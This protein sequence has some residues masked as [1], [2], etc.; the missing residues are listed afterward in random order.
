MEFM[1]F[2]A[3]YDTAFQFRSKRKVAD[4]IEGCLRQY[5]AR[6]VRTIL[7]VACGTGHYT[8]E[9]ARRKYVTYGLDINRDICRYAR[10][11]AKAEALNMTILRGDMVHFALPVPCDLAVSFFDSLTYMPDV[12]ALTTHFRTVAQALAPQGLYIVEIGVIDDFENHNVEEVWT[13][14][15]RDFTV[16]TTYLRDGWINPADGTFEEHC[17]FR[18]SC[19]EHVAFFQLKF[20]KLALAFENFD[21]I[22]KRSAVFRPLAYYDSFKANALL[23]ANNAPWRVIAVLQK[24]A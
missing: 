10:R 7:D 15:R 9:F 5:A 23:N 2:P 11:R 24:T 22:V 1:S 3:V 16:T 13:E 21:G 19:R 18:A 17:S 6:P 14:V 8:R 4:F 20:V 12:P